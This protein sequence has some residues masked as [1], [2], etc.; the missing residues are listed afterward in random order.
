MVLVR[1]PND[2]TWKVEYPNK[3]QTVDSFPAGFRSG[4]TSRCF[5]ARYRNGH[6][7]CFKGKHGK[8]PAFDEADARA[9]VISIWVDEAVTRSRWFRDKLTILMSKS[10]LCAFFVD[11]INEQGERR[12][13]FAGHKLEKA[14]HDM[15]NNPAIAETLEQTRELVQGVVGGRCAIHIQTSLE[16]V[17]R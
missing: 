1:G 7:E 16:A 2:Q 6:P 5:P 8:F 14:R 10:G 4:V 13:C 15:E 3:N 17:S 12:L 9:D 11:S